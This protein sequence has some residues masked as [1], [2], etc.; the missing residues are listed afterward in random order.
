MFTLP[1]SRRDNPTGQT[2]DDVV[3]EHEL[4]QAGLAVGVVTFQDLDMIDTIIINQLS[5]FLAIQWHQTL[6][7]LSL[8]L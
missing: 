6:G 1:L 5:L 2:S 8:L 4:L 3:F 7:V